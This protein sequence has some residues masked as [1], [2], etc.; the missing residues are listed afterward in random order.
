MFYYLIRIAFMII[1]QDTSIH[2]DIELLNLYPIYKFH[3]DYIFIS[4]FLIHCIFN[5][6]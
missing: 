3:Y 5:P 4:L 1:K 6:R 2:F